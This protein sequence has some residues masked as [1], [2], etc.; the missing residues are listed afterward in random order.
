[1]TAE[2]DQ[3]RKRYEQFQ[4]SLKRIERP[5]QDIEQMKAKL[6]A[7]ESSVTSPNGGVTVVAGPGGSIK[8][9]R[10]SD[11]AA[12]QS[13]AILAGEIMTT[14]RQAVASVARSQAAIVDEHSGGESNAVDRVAQIQAEAVGDN[15]EQ[16]VPEAAPAPAPQAEPSD[17]ADDSPANKFLKGLFYDD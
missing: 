16:P 10:I 12:R 11:E 15:V 3:L 6:A 8:D 14:L 5:A 7:L 2:L 1:M 4:A 13:G 17:G 9:I